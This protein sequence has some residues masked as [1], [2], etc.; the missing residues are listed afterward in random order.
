[1]NTEKFKIRYRVTSDG[2][3][4]DKLKSKHVKTHI[5][6]NGFERANLYFQDDHTQVLVHRMVA[7]EFVTNPNNYTD[8]THID[9]NKANNNATNLKWI[10]RQPHNKGTYIID[11][12]T[13]HGLKQA[14]EQTGIPVNSI[15]YTVSHTGKTNSGHTIVKG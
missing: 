11:G 1:M 6:K 5:D 8:V 12:I 9:G 14:S 4:Y 13:Y 15:R 10:P 2:R 7:E 3:I